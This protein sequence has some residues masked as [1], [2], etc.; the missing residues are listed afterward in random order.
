[1]LLICLSISSLT[2]CRIASIFIDRLFVPH[3]LPRFCVNVFWIAHCFVANI[4]C[5]SWCCWLCVFAA[6]CTCIGLP[7]DTS[8]EY[9][10][11]Q[12]IPKIL[13]NH[14]SVKAIPNIN[15]WSSNIF[16]TP[17]KSRKIQLLLLFVGL[18]WKLERKKKKDERKS[19]IRRLSTFRQISTIHPISFF[20][21]FRLFGFPN[22]FPFFSPTFGFYLDMISRG[23]AHRKLCLNLNYSWN[24]LTN[25][26]RNYMM[27]IFRDLWSHR[28]R[29]LKRVHEK[30]YHVQGIPPPN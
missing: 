25:F 29:N 11:I 3:N 20:S 15:N 21:V 23:R 28:A 5:S 9:R 2:C 17:S 4:V 22:Y 26:I 12:N 14:C 7:T 19:D 18:R 27:C 8:G 10:K 30:V 13:L 1:M 16:W 6:T 24:T